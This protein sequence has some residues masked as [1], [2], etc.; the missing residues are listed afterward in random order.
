M[1]VRHFRL[2]SLTM[3]FFLP[4]FLMLLAHKTLRGFQ[5]LRPG[6]K[7]PAAQLWTT[8]RDSVDTSSWVGNPTLLVVIQPGCQACQGE[9]GILAVLAPSYPA[10]RI[11]LLSTTTDDGG[12]NYPFPVYVDQRALF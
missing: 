9:V 10:V 12:T 6:D 4:G 11:V 5:G 3:V 1:N 7:L 2:V 8:D